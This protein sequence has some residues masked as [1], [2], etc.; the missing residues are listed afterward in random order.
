MERWLLSMFLIFTNL[1]CGKA[2]GDVAGLLCGIGNDTS[3]LTVGLNLS[4]LVGLGLVKND[5][6]DNTTVKDFLN[7]SLTPL[8]S[9]DVLKVKTVE[10]AH[11]DDNTD[12]V[13][14][15]TLS[16]TLAGSFGVA[17][18]YFK[19][20]LGSA[21]STG[22]SA[23]DFINESFS[24]S[25]A[26]LRMPEATPFIPIFQSA[27]Y[28]QKSLAGMKIMQTLNPQADQWALEQTDYTNS[29]AHLTSIRN[30]GS[31]AEEN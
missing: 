13:R 18:Q 31:G 1:S 5:A 11:P 17:S 19:D 9:E 15:L 22:A 6:I 28:F 30:D 10:T 2:G 16:G 25:A 29:L 23:F 27:S 3:A 24:V 14:F 8:V 21:G 12:S 26:V 7:S 4:E 20:A